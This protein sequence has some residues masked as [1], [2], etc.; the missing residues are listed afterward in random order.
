[1]GRATVRAAVLVPALGFLLFPSVSRS[2]RADE[3]AAL[4]L[5]QSGRDRFKAGD[6]EEALKDL[7]KA[8]GLART[9][10]SGS[11]WP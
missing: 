1:M 5:Y 4:I 10:S 7:E 8:W 3:D 9:C 6:L 11:T 2:Q